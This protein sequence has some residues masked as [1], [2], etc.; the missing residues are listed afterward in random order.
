[1]TPRNCLLF[2][3]ALLLT[4]AVVPAKKKEKP[5]LPEVVLRA[6]TVAV[7]I[8][9]EAGEPAN[10]PMA[11][12]KAQEDVEKALMKWGRFRFVMET[13]SADLVIS[14]KKGNDKV[15]TP[16][17]SGGQVDNRPVVLESTDNAIR[18]GAQQG[19]SPDAQQT[20]D[21]GT[22][23]G[24][25]HTGM[26]VGQQ[27]DAFKVYLGGES[28]TPYSAPI[29]TYKAKNGLRPPEVPA[30]EEFHK[31]ITDSEKA[32]AQKKQPAPPKPTP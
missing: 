29:W 13:S 5:L 26:E 6:E 14:V 4:P 8:Q 25:A 11:N 1:V 23:D 20:Q 18:I 3:L 24:R 31:A 9:P 16:T 2:V 21:P 22:A 32:A 17:I 7:I 15:A 19:K 30:V 12:R 10:D 28:Y 27:E